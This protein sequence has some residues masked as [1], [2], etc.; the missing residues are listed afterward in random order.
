MRRALGK[1]LSQLL[2]EQTDASATE[3]AID[4]I[5]PNPRQP[6]RHFDA[7]SLAELAASIREY[8]VIQPLLV[9]PVSEGNYE[10]IAGERRLRAAKEAGLETVPVTIRSATGQ[11]SLELAIIENLQREDINAMECARAYQ[12]LIQDFGLTQEQV[13]VRVGKSRTAVANQLRLLRLPEVIQEGVESGA[14][15][16]GHARALLATDSPARQ[17]ALYEKILVDGLSVR[18][19]ERLAKAEPRPVAAKAPKAEAEYKDP[20]LIQTLREHFSAPVR[21]QTDGKRGKLSIE[22][23]SEEDLTRIVERLGLHLDGRE[24]SGE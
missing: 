23:F 4:R 19:T 9:R 12:H 7:E 11:N 13:S 18:E 15:S 20:V 24:L 5:A 16:E 1:G 10:L 3:V 8:G 17:L 6:R 21:I 2:A 14:I 22:F